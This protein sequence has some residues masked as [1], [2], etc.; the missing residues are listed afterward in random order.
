MSLVD[1]F[2][3]DRPDASAKLLLTSA[4][5]WVVIGTSLGMLMATQFVF[6]DITKGI[7]QLSFSRIR[8]THVNILATV[9]ISQAAVGSIFYMLPRLLKTPLFSE[10]LGTVTGWLWNLFALLIPITLLN[11]Y[12]EGRE[13]A[14]L[15]APMDWFFLLLLA[16]AAINTFGTVA[17]RKEKQLYVSVWYFMGS[18]V[19]MA[20][21]WIVG[22]RTF[23][24]LDGLNDA[25]ANWFYAH[26]V[27][28]LWI[29]TTGVG[30]VYYLLPK[31]TV[32][33]NGE[34]GNAIFSHRLSLIGFWGLFTFYTGIGT[35]HIIQ[36][37]VPEW[38]KAFSIG[39]SVLMSVPVYATTANFFLSTQGRWDNMAWNMP[40]RFITWG[41]ICYA[42]VS[43]QGSFQAIRAINWY[44]HFTGWV[45][46][47]A[48]LALLG[49]FTAIFW[50]SIYFIL[51]RLYAIDWYS[52]KL[53]VVHW[54]TFTIGFALFFISWTTAGL[55]QSSAWTFG[56]NVQQVVPWLRVFWGAREV[57][58]G[59]MILGVYFFAY[60]AL[61]T[62]RAAKRQMRPAVMPTLA[63][64]PAAA[65]D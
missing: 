19:G 1:R 57:G 25:I 43:F 48:H 3:P 28:G 26:D 21:V 33:R 61:Q 32:G 34:R 7:P 41:W 15:V 42:L 10:R 58:A 56:L 44:V 17:R 23:V 13:W 27:L 64:A 59:V 31:L 30:V 53:V 2:F 24:R 5:V 14:E 54:W 9:W 22:N 16:F 38:L 47:H 60:N 6:P 36:S 51:P 37:P 65:D 11:G 49:S 46:A 62:V 20:M 12:S 55:V 29:T 35:H 63:P 18:M 4:I 39:S 52:K 8:P 45:S 40:L 50:G